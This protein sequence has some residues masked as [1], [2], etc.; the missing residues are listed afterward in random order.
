MNADHHLLIGK[1]YFNHQ[2]EM[3][4]VWAVGMIAL[5]AASPHGL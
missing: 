4:F 2:I 1:K 3:G 5:R